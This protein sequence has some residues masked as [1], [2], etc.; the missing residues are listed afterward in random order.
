MSSL[1]ILQMKNL[2]KVLRYPDLKN[3]NRHLSKDCDPPCPCPP[4]PAPNPCPKPPSSCPPP[5]LMPN[6]GRCDSIS[7]LNPCNYCPPPCPEEGYPTE[8]IK[9][10]KRMQCFYQVTH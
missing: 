3:L 7:A 10:I 8:A 1:K 4:P 2:F 9:K 6:Q 5:R